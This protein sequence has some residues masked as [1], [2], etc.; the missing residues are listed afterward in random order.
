[1]ALTIFS[2]CVLS[3]GLIQVV[4]AVNAPECPPD[5]PFVNCTLS[6]CAVATPCD[7]NPDA[8]CKPDYCGGC[9][10]KY[11]EDGDKE[12]HCETDI[13][14]ICEL[15]NTTI[16]CH[17]EKD[18]NLVMKILSANYGRTDNTTC[19]HPYDSDQLHYHTNCKAANSTEIVTGWCHGKR[20]CHPEV[21]NAIFGDP[22]EGTYKYLLVDF[23]CVNKD[24]ISAAAHTMT[25]MYSALAAIAAFL[26]LSY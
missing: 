16:G 9:V 17:E 10:A 12:V 1:M 15:K 5:R 7:T 21:S 14:L 20:S 19:R 3:I 24:E 11:Y 18:E 25:T 8:E 23:Q 22:C 26:L 6:P 4:F 2:F 13:G